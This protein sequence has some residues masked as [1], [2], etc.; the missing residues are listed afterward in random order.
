M[1]DGRY[2]RLA[3]NSFVGAI[4]YNFKVSETK[5]LPRVSKGRKIRSSY[6]LFSFSL[7]VII[8]M[9]LL[10]IGVMSR[11]QPGESTIAQRFRIMGWLLVGM[12][13]I[14]NP[15]CVDLIIIGI[16]YVKS[17]LTR[18]RYLR[19]HESGPSHRERRHYRQEIKIYASLFLWIC[20]YLGFLATPAIGRFVV[21]GQMLHEYGSCLSLK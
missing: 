18:R 8:T 21:I 4:L 11:F 16:V 10:V 2:W 3:K 14:N 6:I 7:L 12:V 9:P 19:T 20:M 13:A 1:A 17:R 15:F 5:E